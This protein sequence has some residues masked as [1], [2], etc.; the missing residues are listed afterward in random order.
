MGQ[1]GLLQLAASVLRDGAADSELE[2]IGE[3]A[4]VVGVA[5]DEEALQLAMYGIVAAEG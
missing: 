2:S 1:R 5:P 4:D 3:D